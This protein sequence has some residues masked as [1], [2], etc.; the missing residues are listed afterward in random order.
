MYTLYMVGWV[1][2]RII[3]RFGRKRTHP[4]SGGPSTTSACQVLFAPIVQNFRKFT[5]H[6]TCLPQLSRIMSY[7]AETYQFKLFAQLPQKVLDKS[8]VYYYNRRAETCAL[9]FLH[10]YP[11]KY[12]TSSIYYCII[13]APAPI[14]SKKTRPF[15]LKSSKIFMHDC[16]K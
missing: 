14:C 15:G 5:L 13:G 16:R 11:K 7:P 9:N 8:S 6:C 1:L 3:L 4:N 10:N 12:L 2:S